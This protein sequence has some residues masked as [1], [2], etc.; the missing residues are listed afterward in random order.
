VSWQDIPQLK[1]NQQATNPAAYSEHSIGFLVKLTVFKIDYRVGF[2]LQVLMLGEYISGCFGLQ[3]G[4][5]YFLP[6][7]KLNN[8]PHQAVTK[9]A[10]AIEK[11]HR[12][13]E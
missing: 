13:L 11:D 12:I 1:Y 3:A 6:P 8:N 5:P 2:G 9:I 7:V 4:K 10:N